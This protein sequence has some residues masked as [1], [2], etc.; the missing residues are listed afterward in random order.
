MPKK[1]NPTP[2]LSL[3]LSLADLA[4]G[5]ARV[6]LAAPRSSTLPVLGMVA[7]TA[8]D[9]ALTLRCTNL[10]LFVTATVP[11]RV[12]QPGSICVPAY[13]LTRIVALLEPGDVT[14]EADAK[15]VLTLS[16]GPSVFKL[17]GLNTEEMPPDPE[18]G[19]QPITWSAP[20]PALKAWLQQTSFLIEYNPG[21]H[22]LAGVFW[23]CNG[24]LQL[25]GTDRKRIAVQRPALEGLPKAEFILAERGVQALIS[26]LGE[27]GDVN[28]CLG[29]RWIGCATGQWTLRSRLIE[30]TFPPWKAPFEGLTIEPRT[31]V[32]RAELIAAI[33][34]LL[35]AADVVVLRRRNGQ[36][37]LEA[38]SKEGADATET[39]AMDAGPDVQCALNGRYMTE[40]LKAVETQYLFLSLPRELNTPLLITTENQEWTCLIS[41]MRLPEK[42]TPQPVAAP[43]PDSAKG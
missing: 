35:W 29:E 40:V 32:D 7:L 21:Q 36:L 12:T 23:E 25:V 43:A 6:R 33:H 39:L 26:L 3:T 13:L 24:R 34:R 28:L 16:C 20:Q 10:D 30:G 18:L 5:M 2:I 31:Q 41:Q 1:S 37:E 14:L 9:D 11:A 17:L 22:Q 15:H 42:I 27:E 38:W 4:T 8:Q 19:A